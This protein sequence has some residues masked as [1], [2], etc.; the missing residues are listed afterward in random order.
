MN[1]LNI[2]QWNI[3]GY[4]VNY[5]ELQALIRK[6]DIKIISIQESHINNNISNIPV[7]IN[8]TMYNYNNS[9]SFGGVSLLIHNSIQ[10]YP[11]SLNNDLETIGFEIHSKIKFKIISTYISPN[12][13]FSYNN[14]QNVFN[15]CRS[16]TLITG[17]FN[18][19]HHNW[20]SSR[21]NKRGTIIDSFINNNNLILLNDKSPTHFST[22]NTLTNIDLTL[23][24]PDLFLHSN[25][26]IENDLWGSDHFPII[27]S[28]FENNTD[29]SHTIKPQFK[30]DKANWE[31]YRLK[32]ATF[33]ALRP[34]DKNINK[35]AANIKKII[36]QSSN[37]SIPQPKPLT[38]RIPVPWWNSHL[39]LL[40]KEKKTG[41]LNYLMKIS[42]IL[43]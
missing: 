18:S 2:L 14:L 36:I 10:H 19:W 37:E 26:K 41:C 22:Q 27:I 40:K 30:T 43:I 32:C 31:L 34:I 25:W 35:E 12:V 16:P 8:F 5:N 17:D 4:N 9:N 38:K 23:C 42:T 3:R 1:R 39:T 20:G 21:N 33:E 24:T 7:P 28:L 15:D 11:I 29:S 6:H 13:Y